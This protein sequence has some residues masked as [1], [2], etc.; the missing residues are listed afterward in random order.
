MDRQKFLHR[1][2]T[3]GFDSQP[4]ALDALVLLYNVP[5]AYEPLVK[6]W[7]LHYPGTSRALRRLVRMG[8]VT[9]QPP[10]VIDTRSGRTR[11]ASSRSVRRFR[12]TAKGRRLLDDAED[13][14]RVLED[15]FPKT[16]AKNLASVAALLAACELDGSHARYGLSAAHATE[17]SGLCERSGR[18]WVARLTRA[19]YLRELPVRYADVREVIP[20]HW[21][22][23]RGLSRQL[24]TVLAAFRPNDTLAVELRLDRSKYLGP[25]DPARLG[26]SGATDFDH[27]VQAQRVLA[28]L[29]ASPRCVSQG[30]VLVEPRHFLPVHRAHDPWLFDK[31]GPSTVFYQPDAELRERGPGGELRRC[32]LEYERYQSRRDGWNHIERFLGYLHTKTL[33][34]EPSVLRFVVDSNQR[35]RS[36]RELIEAFADWSLDHPDAMP[37]ND[38]TLAVSSVDA[39]LG[40]SD[41][42][43]PRHWFVIKVSQPPADPQVVFHERGASP[44]D[45]YFTR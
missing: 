4:W 3:F 16:T 24:A 19:G 7:E 31:D 11:D 32:V 30:R 14:I 17:L 37:L 25:I 22:P 9:H 42:L 12:T 29:L 20:A 43:D 15:A 8:F 38:V 18:W 21:R 10:V 2:E 26:I 35:V 34:L 6:A 13:D 1:A 5:R 39:V 33:G 45:V 28:A 36:Y 41:P 23:T 40:A 44:Y 27:D